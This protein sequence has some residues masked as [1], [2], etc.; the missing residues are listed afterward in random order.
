MDD[1]M[2]ILLVLFFTLSILNADVLYAKKKRCILDNYYFKD[3]KFHYTYS[4]TNR[5]ASTSTYKSSDLEFGYE[6]TDNK[7]QKLQILKT[8]NLEYHDYQF[9]SSLVGLFLGFTLFFFSLFIFVKR[10]L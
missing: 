8:L 7:C 1:M 9:L 10:G 6:Y 3:N 2:R 4:S 5:N